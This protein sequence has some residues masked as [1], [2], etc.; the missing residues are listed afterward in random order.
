MKTRR[1]DILKAAYDLMGVQGLESLTA[2][3]VAAELGINHATVHYYF[4]HREDLLAGIAE[5][6]LDQLKRDRAKFHVGADKP[7]DKVEAELALAEAYCRKS[8]RFAKVLAGLYVAS[9]ADA[10]LRKKN[11]AI[12]SEW[13][14]LLVD[15][16][17]TTKLKKDTPYA[18]GELLAATFFGLMLTSHLL[19]GKFSAKD[20]VDEIYASMFG[21]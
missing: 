2:R 15:L 14:G 19:D 8:S 5:F 1:P 13:S 3:N 9:I 21:G 12:W 11:S 7:A 17:R 16:A 20:K 4:P 10:A 6:T 18:D